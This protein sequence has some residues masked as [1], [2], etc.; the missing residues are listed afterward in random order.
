MKEKTNSCKSIAIKD[1]LLCGTSLISTTGFLLFFSSA[2]RCSNT[3]LPSTAEVDP[4]TKDASVVANDIVAVEEEEFDKDE[5][6]G[7]RTVQSSLPQDTIARAK[8]GSSTEKVKSGKDGTLAFV[9]VY[10]YAAKIRSGEMTWEEVEKTDLD[11]VYFTNHSC[12][13]KF[14]SFKNILSYHFF[15]AHFFLNFALMPFY[16]SVLNELE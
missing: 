12:L 6:T 1:L 4:A 7:K 10:E 5:R 11:T 14:F 9:D 16:S 8:K 13:L 15:Y 3:F 2:Q